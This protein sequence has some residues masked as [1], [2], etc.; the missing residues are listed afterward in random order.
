M[1]QGVNRVARK[2]WMD[3]GEIL[4]AEILTSAKISSVEM[5]ASAGRYDAAMGRRQA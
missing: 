5:M 2:D 4:E 1:A 3:I